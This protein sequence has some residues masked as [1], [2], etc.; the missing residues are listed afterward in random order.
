MSE[1]YHF[2]SILTFFMQE[3]VYFTDQHND[4]T[5]VIEWKKQCQNWLSI[6]I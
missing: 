1:R 3:H 6:D 4:M 5:L 2:N